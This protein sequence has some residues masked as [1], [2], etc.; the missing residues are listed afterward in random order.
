M[1]RFVSVVLGASLCVFVATTAQAQIALGIR[2]GYNSSTAT[3]KVDD[4]KQ[5]GLTSRSGFHGGVD[6]AFMA[7]PIVGVEVGGLYSQKGLGFEAEDAKIKLDYIDIPLVVAINVPTNSQITPRLFLGGVG[8]IEIS[9]K[10]S[11]GDVSVDCTDEEIGARKSFYFSAIGGAGI[12][13]AAGPGT[14]LIQ[15]DYQLGLTN[16]SDEEGV[17]VKG[18]AIQA[19]VGYRFPVGG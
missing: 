2:G 18:H 7:S 15:A 17:S 10:A 16:I 12:A 4:V 8:S 3:V 11:A 5:E 6:L 9:C 14:F 13:V 19:S 1:R